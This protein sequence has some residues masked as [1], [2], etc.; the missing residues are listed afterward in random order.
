[1]MNLLGLASV[2]TYAVKHAP[3]PVLVVKDGEEHDD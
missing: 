2:S 3:C 1:M